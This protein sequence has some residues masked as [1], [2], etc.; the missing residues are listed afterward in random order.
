M[1]EYEGF[2]KKMKEA[3]GKVDY[4]QMFS[5][6]EQKIHAAPKVRLTLAGALALLLISFIAY[7][8]LLSPQPNGDLLMSYV[9]E[10]EEIDGPLL[11]YVFYENGTF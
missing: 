3:E 9:F 11:E 5:R 4:S 2:I 1:R 7:F 6:I 8:A 10:P